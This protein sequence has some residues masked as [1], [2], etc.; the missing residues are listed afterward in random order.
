MTRVPLTHEQRVLMGRIG[1]HT[2]WA[3]TPDRA[4]R[5]APARAAYQ[6]RFEREADPDGTLP[7]AERLRRAKALQSAYMARLALRSSRARTRATAA[8]REATELDEQA[9]SA[10]TELADLEAGET[11]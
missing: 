4:A 2:S 9:H 7:D 5:T 11:E 10:D 3:R 8:R 1:G 6:R